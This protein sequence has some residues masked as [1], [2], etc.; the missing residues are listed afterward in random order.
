[1][2]VIVCFSRVGAPGVKLHGILED[3][4]KINQILPFASEVTAIMYMYIH[5]MYFVDHLFRMW[6]SQA[7]IPQF[8]L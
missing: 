8:F 7:R 4:E 6:I 5:T 1:M 3:I 2:S